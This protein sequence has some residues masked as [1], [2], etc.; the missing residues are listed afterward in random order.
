MVFFI[1]DR[2]ERFLGS[3]ITIKFPPNAASGIC[4]SNAVSNPRIDPLTRAP[5]SYAILPAVA[6]TDGAFP[7]S[8][9]VVVE[10]EGSFAKGYGYTFKS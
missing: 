5:R 3:P 1:S 6:Q 9:K 10:R 2:M 4:P 8:T 7:G